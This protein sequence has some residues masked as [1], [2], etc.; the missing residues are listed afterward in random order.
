LGSGGKVLQ[1][2]HSVVGAGIYSASSLV[3]AFSDA[4]FDVTFSLARQMLSE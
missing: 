4:R 1:K 2:Y 3:V